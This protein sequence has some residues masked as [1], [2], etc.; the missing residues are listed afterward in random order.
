VVLSL[1]PVYHRLYDG[2]LLIFPLCWS[3]REFSGPANK[4]ARAAFLLLLP[5]LV[6]GGTALEQFQLR[7]WVPEAI[8]HSWYWTAIV[9]PHQI[10]FL[11]FLSLVLL[12][13]MAVGRH[14]PPLSSAR[15]NMPSA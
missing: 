11:L 13:Q 15:H 10:W 1:F 7:G 4:L 14:F 3:L 12:R 6:P 2:F 5:F 9:M 8:A